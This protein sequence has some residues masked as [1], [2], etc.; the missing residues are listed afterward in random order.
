VLSHVVEIFNLKMGDS[1]LHA[2]FL[3]WKLLLRTTSSKKK[4]RT[5][6]ARTDAGAYDIELNLAT[7]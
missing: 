2:T 7:Q 5:N 6:V 1:D 3:M 4:S